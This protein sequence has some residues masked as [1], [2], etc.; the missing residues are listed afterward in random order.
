MENSYCCKTAA[1][2]G[3][4]RKSSRDGGRTW[5]CSH[6]ERIRSERAHRQSSRPLPPVSVVAVMPEIEIQSRKQC[7][8]LSKGK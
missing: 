2:P 3:L 7:F 6:V 1:L 4:E 5:L 8:F